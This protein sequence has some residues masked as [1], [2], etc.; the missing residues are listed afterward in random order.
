MNFSFVPNQ[1]LMVDG[2]Y[3]AEFDVKVNRIFYYM[4]ADTDKKNME[5]EL[6][7]RKLDGTK[8]PAHRVKKLNN[9]S[10][11]SLWTD[12]M[13]AEL[14]RWERKMLLL[15]LQTS[16]KDAE[17]IKVYHINSNGCKNLEGKDI[18]VA[19]DYEYIPKQDGIRIDVDETI[20]QMKWKS[21]VHPT[22]K[23]YAVG[24]EEDYLMVS[25]RSSEIIFTAVLLSAIKFLFVEAGFN[26]AVCI[27]LY[28]KT[29]SY[30]TALTQAMMYM[31]SPSY[32]MCS[33]VND[34][35]KMAVRKVKECY[36]FPVVLEDYHEGA[37]GYDYKRQISMMDAVVR[38]I[39]GNPQS[40]VV[41]ITS[42]YL[43]GV[44]SLQARTLQIEAQNVDLKILDKIQKEQTMADIIMN[45][46]KVLLEQK[47]DVIETIQKQYE[48]FSKH[49]KKAMR[50]EESIVFLKITAV[51]YEK[52]IDKNGRLDLSSKLDK[53][54]A[55]QKEKQKLHL[56]RI[57][58]SEEEYVIKMIY[59]M[60]T[61]ETYKKYGHK[62]KAVY[63]VG[64]KEVFVGSDG[65][66]LSRPALIYGLKEHNYT[67]RSINKMIQILS[68]LGFL[69]ED[70]GGTHTKKLSGKRVYCIRY[71]ELKEQYKELEST[72]K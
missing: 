54:L 1:G 11:F 17:Q 6:V 5:Y 70:C 22:D 65:V 42:E 32:F 16:C 12:I 67:G 72:R 31:E 7:A 37:T 24:K 56:S 38:H 46:L 4:Q 51:L 35:K 62:N 23:G 57:N 55:F 66:Y 34:Q 45:F 25:Q 26:P 10:Y 53:A 8:L 49:G 48:A 18:F 59:Q 3:V 36:G 71:E 9:L 28:G 27:N 41:F 39:E 33:L 14:E 63:S 15:R 68:K 61:D 43:D 44:E 19:G 40:A 20:K 50:I 21:K 29:G 47:K 52:Y 2:K 30:K 58:M 69:D 64:E 13:D 60:L